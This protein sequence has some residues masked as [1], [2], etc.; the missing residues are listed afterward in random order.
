MWGLT[1]E[2]ARG[3][4]IEIWPDNM[5]TVNTFIACLTQWRVGMNGATG[6]DYTVIPTVLKLTEV[7]EGEWRDVFHGIRL[8]EDGALQQMRNNK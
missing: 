1:I 2:E 4:A 3:P 6:L 8:M 5:T 7:P